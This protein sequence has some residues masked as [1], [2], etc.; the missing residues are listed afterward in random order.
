MKGGTYTGSSGMV[1]RMCTGNTRG[2]MFGVFKD[3]TMHSA[4]LPLMDVK[5]FAPELP[6]EGK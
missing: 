4:L 2:V 5:A 3:S 6:L 1:L